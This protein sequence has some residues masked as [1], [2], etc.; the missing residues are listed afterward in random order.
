MKSAQQKL[1]FLDTT[2]KLDQPYTVL[3]EIPTNTPLPALYRT[4][5]HFWVALAEYLVVCGSA[6]ICFHLV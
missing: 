4:T 5:L 6:L 3:Y 1:I 2:V